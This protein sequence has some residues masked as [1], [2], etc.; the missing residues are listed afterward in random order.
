MLQSLCL[1][2]FIAP[3]DNRTPVRILQHPDEAHHALNTARWVVAGLRQA[4]LSCGTQFLPHHWCV[5]G[6]APVL[7]FPASDTDSKQSGGSHAEDQQGVAADRQKNSLVVIDGTWRQ[8]AAIIRQHP[9]L[10]ALPRI[11]LPAS[12]GSKYRLRKSPRADGLSTVE[13]VVAAL[14]IMDAPTSHAAVLRPFLI[15]IDRQIALQRKRMGE[16]AF[17]HNYPHLSWPPGDPSDSQ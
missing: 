10:T 14:D 3:M 12:S 1:C 2:A 17:R 11:T 6:F 13:A 8:A 9:G 4:S 15:Q 7:L 5:A 16:Q